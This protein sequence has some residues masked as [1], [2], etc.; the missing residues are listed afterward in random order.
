[1]LAQVVDKLSEYELDTGQHS[2]CAIVLIALTYLSEIPA[3]DQSFSQDCRRRN[4]V[5][6]KKIA[7]GDNRMQLPST[8]VL[9]NVKPGPHTKI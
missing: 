3:P 6:I 8:E 1:M 2:L 9:D 5:A 7:N 4:L